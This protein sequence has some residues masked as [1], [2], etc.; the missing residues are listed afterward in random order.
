MK[1]TATF[2]AIFVSLC[3]IVLFAWAS[4]VHAQV[5]DTISGSFTS[6][7]GDAAHNFKD[8]EIK[9]DIALPRLYANGYNPQITYVAVS[10]VRQGTSFITTYEAVIEES[11]DGKAWMGFTARGSYGN[12]NIPNAKCPPNPSKQ[13]YQ[14]RADGQITGCENA[15]GKSLEQKLKASLG[16]EDVQIITI[17]DE[18]AVTVREYFI[19]FTKPAQY[20]P[21][22]T[23]TSGNT[24]TNNQT[25]QT[26]TSNNT[27]STSNNN[28]P[29]PSTNQ[30]SQTIEGYGV[31]KTPGGG[32]GTCSDGYDNDGDGRTDWNGGKNSNGELLPPD[33]VCIN[34][35]SEE[36][37]DEVTGSKIA[38]IP[39]VNKCDLGSFMQLI[40]NLITL[41]IKFLLFPVAVLL[42]VYAG[43]KY[44]TA[45][46][47]AS[48]KANVKKMI[49]NFLLGVLLMLCAWLIV[50]TV[51]VVVGYTD[52]LYFF[53]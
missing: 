21:H 26:G 2:K 16:A 35:E 29:A 40:N 38:L 41:M 22:T 43:F 39:C 53:D 32:K 3:L 47:N 19:Q 15:D 24:N 1:Q 45:E 6:T 52:R 17:Y 30:T 14:I 10:I 50:K 7:N 46:G 18:A 4:P 5:L 51:L 34:A 42:F 28:T 23:T 20:P 37:A 9:V 27:P 33:P 49:K 25:Q 13:N 44:I 8:L 11:A 48:K 12:T 31:S 36:V